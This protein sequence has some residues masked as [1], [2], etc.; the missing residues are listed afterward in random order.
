MGR[1]GTSFVDCAVGLQRSKAIEGCSEAGWNSYFFASW[2]RDRQA[3]GEA[4]T[5]ERGFLTRSIIIDVRLIF[6]ILC[7]IETLTLIQGPLS[8]TA[9]KLS[10]GIPR[11][12]SPRG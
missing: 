7:L 5:Q 1:V 4:R 3:F 6:L 11:D 9:G 10:G 8:N 12:H 2:G